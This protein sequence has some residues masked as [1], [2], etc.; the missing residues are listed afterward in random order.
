M[1]ASSTA[2]A[3]LT[4]WAADMLNL[5]DLLAA[6]YGIDLAAAIVHKFNVVS[7]R[8]DFPERLPRDRR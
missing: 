7:E 1:S 5:A 8:Q 6:K 2:R 4:R 3:I